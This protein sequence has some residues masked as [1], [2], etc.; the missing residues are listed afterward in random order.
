MT[1]RNETRGA[2]GS[3]KSRSPQRLSIV[4]N[5]AT[6]KRLNRIKEMMEADTTTDAVK[7]AL[8]LLEYFLSVS[9]RGG[10]FFI[11]MPDEEP[12]QLEVF[13]ISTR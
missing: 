1:K 10:K 2:A 4:L 12:R 8:R 11:Q 5:D 9:D 6:E 3:S 7:D 13:G